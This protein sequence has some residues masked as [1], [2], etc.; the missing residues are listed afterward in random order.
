MRLR[1]PTA[2]A[3]CLM[4]AL[5]SRDVLAA[6]EGS[7]ELV[8]S[9]DVGGKGGDWA[10]S[11]HNLRQRPRL[12]RQKR[13]PGEVRRHQRPSLGQRRLHPGQVPRR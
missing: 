3:A 1:A 5:P 10:V 8:F 11:T 2:C 13:L 4:W 6:G 7:Y 12:A 9:T